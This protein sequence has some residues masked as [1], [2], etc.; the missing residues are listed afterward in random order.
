MTLD[1]SRLRALDVLEVAASAAIDDA[2]EPV[3]LVFQPEELVTDLRVDKPLASWRLALQIEHR[4]EMHGLL[5]GD[6]DV[7]VR[8][9]AYEAGRAGFGILA[10]RGIDD[11]TARAAGHHRVVAHGH[12]SVSLYRP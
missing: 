5:E 10:S 4:L 9:P 11:R 12:H 1:S 7:T 3:P 2:G 6:R 8:R